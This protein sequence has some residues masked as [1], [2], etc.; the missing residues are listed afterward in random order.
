M[1]TLNRN[2]VMKVW[3]LDI[4]YHE[5]KNAVLKTASCKTPIHSCYAYWHNK[6]YTETYI[7]LHDGQV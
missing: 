1:K 7:F 5:D 6:Y 4:L 2:E 3:R